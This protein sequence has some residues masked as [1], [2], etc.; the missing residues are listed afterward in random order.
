LIL[1]LVLAGVFL[2]FGVVSGINSLRGVEP[3]E[4][5][6]ARFLLAVHDAAKAGFWLALGGFF[7]GLALIEEPQSFRWF[8]LAPVLMAGVRLLT[9]V[10]LARA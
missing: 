3:M 1:E 9:A 8:A 4:E 2:L 6:R 7:L 5:G 10:F